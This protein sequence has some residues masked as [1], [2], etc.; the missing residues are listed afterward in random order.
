MR[1]SNCRHALQRAGTGLHHA[2]GAR[3]HAAAHGRDVA[4]VRSRRGGIA[5]ERARRTRCRNLAR[6]VTKDKLAVGHIAQDGIALAPL[7]GQQFLGQR[8]LNELSG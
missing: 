3:G 4:G 1:V 7:T 2:A 5:T 6:A 8:V